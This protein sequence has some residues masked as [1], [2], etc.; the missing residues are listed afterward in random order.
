MPPNIGALGDDVDEFDS[1]WEGIGNDD[2]VNI[3]PSVAND[4]DGVGIDSVDGFNCVAGDEDGLANTN[5][6]VNDSGA[7]PSKDAFVGCAH[8]FF[9][10]GAWLTGLDLIFLL[11]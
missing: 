4:D 5:G 8:I 10:I 3:V 9:T 7:N 2:P 11:M 6:D 1:P